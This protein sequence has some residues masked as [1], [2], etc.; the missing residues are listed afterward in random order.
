MNHSCKQGPANSANSEHCEQT[1]SPFARSQQCEQRTVRTSKIV[2]TVRTTN[3]VNGS[4]CPNSAN[5]EQCERFIL[6]EQCE[7]FILSE[8]CVIF[9][10]SSNRANSENR[11]EHCS[12]EPAL[13]EPTH[14]ISSLMS[15]SSCKILQ[16]LKNMIFFYH[17]NMCT[18]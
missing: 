13:Q 7:R 9:Q 11:C 10:K 6:S 18:T 16:V 3:S 4:Y 14:G 8:Q 1:C 17:S 12:V 2:R 5:S 15:D